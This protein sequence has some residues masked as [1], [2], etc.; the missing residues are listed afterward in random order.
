M[1]RPSS[2]GLSAHSRRAGVGTRGW[3]ESIP[4]Y[5]TR[6]GNRLR[7]QRSQGGGQGEAEQQRTRRRRTGKACPRRWTAYAVAAKRK[8]QF[9][10]L[11]HHISVEV[12]DRHLAL[13]RMLRASTAD[14]A[15]LRGRPR[16][17]A[18]GPARTVHRGAYRLCRPGGGT[19][20]SRMV[21]S[22]RSRWRPSKTRSSRG[23]RPGAERDY[24][25]DFLVLV[26]FRRCRSQ[27]DALMRSW[28]DHQQE[29]ELR[30]GRRYRRFF[31]SLSYEW[32]IRLVSHRIGDTRI[33]RLIKKC[34]RRGPRR[35]D[36]DGR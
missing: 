35:R 23:D 9:T 30:S 18:R 31:D 28:S 22:V 11:F 14:V 20:R 15:G 12:L 3:P 17:S 2:S 16:A 7:S 19:Y 13:K 27:H 10:T 36:R 4:A 5:A 1:T 26:R 8:E 34:S 6:P 32:L 21:G 25:E 24:E 33:I 29:G